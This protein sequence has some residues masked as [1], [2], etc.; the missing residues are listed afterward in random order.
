MSHCCTEV[1]FR[2][3]AKE[4]QSPKT[5]KVGFTI[6]YSSLASTNKTPFV[7]FP[8]ASSALVKKKKKHRPTPV[9]TGPIPVPILI[10]KM[11]QCFFYVK[12]NKILVTKQNRNKIKIEQLLTYK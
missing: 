4:D 10:E 7:S 9:H 8:A 1:M 2:I 5:L 6:Y 11:A 12:S 3:K